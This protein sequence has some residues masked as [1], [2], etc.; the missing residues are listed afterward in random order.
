M[1]NDIMSTMIRP[2]QGRTE[3]E[4]CLELQKIVWG[5]SDLDVVPV[6]MFVV[7]AKTGGHVL[8]AFD[9]SHLVGFALGFSALRE[10]V[11]F[12]HSHMVAVL[13]EYQD[14]GVGRAL[15]LHQREE[16]LRRG[17]RRIEWTFDPLEIK[18]ARFNIVRLGAI[19]RKVLPNLYGVTSSPLHGGLPTDRLV[20]E[21]QLDSPRVT[22]VLRGETPSRVGAAQL[23][24][25]ANIDELR[26]RDPETAAR[27]QGTL[28]AEAEYWFERGHAITGF[29]VGRE[30]AT[31]LLE[32]VVD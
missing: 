5:Y 19:V 21:W 28:R 8:G 14:R 18:N 26:S 23:Q 32:P 22:A 10:D 11:P 15:K 3:F 6:P 20:A 7:A 12:V 2:C 29:E 4:G 16:C 25:P 27:V 24:L 9:G 30:T 1:R 17:I 31:Y 13:P